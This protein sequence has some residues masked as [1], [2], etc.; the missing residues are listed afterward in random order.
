M[1]G[2]SFMLVATLLACTS[3]G[4]RLQ[5]LAEVNQQSVQG[6]GLNALA[7][8]LLPES[9]PAGFSVPGCGRHLGVKNPTLYNMNSKSKLALASVRPRKPKTSMSLVAG[10]TTL[11][12]GRLTQ[13]ALVA[14]LSANNDEQVKEDKELQDSAVASV[15]GKGLASKFQAIFSTLKTK[16]PWM[17]CAIGIGADL[18]AQV[19]AG[20]RGPADWIPRQ[21][22]SMAIWSLGYT[23]MCR[24]LVD[25]MFD[26][27]CG[28]GTS[29]QEVFR[30][31]LF[32]LFLFKPFIHVPTLYMC[33]GMMSGKGFLGSWHKMCHVY[34]ETMTF[35][36]LLWPVPLYI[37]FKHIPY[38]NA[39][40]LFYSI[41]AFVQ[42]CGFSY[43]SL[44]GKR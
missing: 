26:R 18:C 4:R 41:I 43:L 36:W 24:P 27:I 14:Q 12:D 7:A 9:A 35:C 32:E 39:R 16:K 10:N 44:P 17:A 29:T 15:P 25:R 33:T 11:I 21:T 3:H 40:V 22:L 19:I 34:T 23:G 28:K 20:A 42:K 13:D 6:W 31:S 8:L 38:G 5:H 30:K 2:I 1:W 37:Y